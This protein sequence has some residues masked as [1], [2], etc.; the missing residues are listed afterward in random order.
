[1]TPVELEKLHQECKGYARENILR[2][3][4]DLQ[5]EQLGECEDKLETVIDAAY[6]QIESDNEAMAVS[7]KS[8]YFLYSQLYAKLFRSIRVDQLDEDWFGLW[9]QVQLLKS[10]TRF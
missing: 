7:Y 1:M 6:Q 3:K 10:I 5:Q 4:A 2:H 8:V 9:L